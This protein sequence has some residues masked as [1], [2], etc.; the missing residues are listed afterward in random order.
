MFN[1]QS[2]LD[3]VPKAITIEIENGMSH[4]VLEDGCKYFLRWS[5]FSTFSQFNLS[6]IGPIKIIHINN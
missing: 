4:P 5:Y 1:C 3:V 6:Y 2:L